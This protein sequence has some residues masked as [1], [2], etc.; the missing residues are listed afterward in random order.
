MMRILGEKDGES[1]EWENKNITVKLDYRTGEFVSHLTN[2]DFINAALPS[3]QQSETNTDERRFTIK[4]TFPIDEIID[5]EQINQNYGVELQLE[6]DDLMVSKT[7]LFEMLITRPESNNDVTYRT[8]SLT[9][10]IYNDEL[11]LPAFEG[12]EHEIEL[13]LIFSGFMNDR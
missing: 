11:N 8:F 7:L 9:G 4:G 12:F 3:D 13:W 5:Q 1:F 2:S 6:N 10:K